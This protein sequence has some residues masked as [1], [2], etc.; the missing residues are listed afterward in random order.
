[1]MRDWIS[2]LGT[3]AI[4]TGLVACEST[5]P[6]P[7]SLEEAKQVT[8]TFEGSSFTPPPRTINDITAILD[9]QPLA[10]PEIV[11][12][13]RE[14]A[15]QE[16]SAGLTGNRLASFYRQRGNAAYRIGDLGHAAADYQEAERLTRG[17]SSELRLFIL[18]DLAAI[19]KMAGNY[20]DGLRHKEETLSYIP[21]KGGLGM[22]VGIP[23][24]LARWQASVGDFEKADQYIGMAEEGLQKFLSR[25][26]KAAEKGNAWAITGKEIA[27]KELAAKER[28]GSGGQGSA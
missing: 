15:A 12:K 1:M 26:R 18:V 19:E 14:A 9:E 6:Q 25:S 28:N 8:A 13:A 3:A 22:R 17:V 16:P 2:H 27:T 11:V 24:S 7:L 10:D 21:E 5:G 23:A 20:R 4:L